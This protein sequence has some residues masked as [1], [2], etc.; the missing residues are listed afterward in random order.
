MSAINPVPNVS[1]KYGAPMG[2]RAQGVGGDPTTPFEL[3]KIRINSGGYDDGGAY[4]GI[5]QPL[6]WYCAYDT[7]NTVETGRCLYC[8][9]HYTAY[10]EGRYG[11][12]NSPTGAHVFP[13]K[14]ED[15]EISNFIRADSREHAKAK[16]R[17][18]YPNAMF[19]RP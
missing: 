17:A 9:Q 11:E 6:Y 5:G 1:A 12:C 4:W 7:D 14:S 16:I 3:R 2:R 10:R 18:K 15:V 8:E 13:T 19:K